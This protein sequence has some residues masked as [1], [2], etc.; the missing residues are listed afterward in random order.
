MVLHWREL[1]KATE[2]SK[3]QLTTSLGKHCIRLTIVIVPS[4]TIASSSTSEGITSSTSSSSA[5]ITIISPYCTIISC[6]HQR[7]KPHAMSIL[8]KLYNNTQHDNFNSAAIDQRNFS[9]SF[10]LHPTPFFCV[11]VNYI[12]AV[13]SA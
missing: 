7:G 9:C 1:Q 5:T 10:I 3:S 11:S 4:N 8:T 6:T 12:N 13:E 2:S